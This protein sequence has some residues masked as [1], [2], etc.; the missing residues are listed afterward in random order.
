MHVILHHICTWLTSPYQSARYTCHQVVLFGGFKHS[1]HGPS[2][3][4]PPI[5]LSNG[6]ISHIPWGTYTSAPTHAMDKWEAHIERRKCLFFYLTYLF[7]SN[8]ISYNISSFL[9]LYYLI[10][11]IDFINYFLCFSIHIHI[12]FFSSS[13]HLRVYLTYIFSWN[14]SLIY[15]CLTW[16]L[17]AHYFSHAYI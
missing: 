16:K 9:S 13:L 12:S 4:S 15:V 2:S 14:L 6:N 10:V 1:I 3:Y 11:I 17:N 8:T 5:I 7:T